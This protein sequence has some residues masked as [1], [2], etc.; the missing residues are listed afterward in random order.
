MSGKPAGFSGKPAGKT[1]H[2]GGDAFVLAL[3]TGLSIP[4]ACKRAGIGITT[5]Y[6]RWDDPAVR[7][8]VS[9]VRD[10]LLGEAVGRLVFRHT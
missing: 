2:K 5:G 9:R 8:E 6:R 4:A 7:Q 1:G 10:R 3:A